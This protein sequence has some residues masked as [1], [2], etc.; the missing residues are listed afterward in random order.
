MLRKMMQRIGGLLAL[1]AITALAAIPLAPQ[2]ALAK[3]RSKAQ[4]TEATEAT[5]V[6]AAPVVPQLPEPPASQHKTMGYDNGFFLETQDGNY[7]LQFQGHFQARF[8]YGFLEQ[9]PDTYTFAVQRGEIDLFGHVLS[10]TLRYFF[11]MNLAT[12]NAATTT[13]VCTDAGCT[14]TANAVT[15]ESTSGVATLNDFFMDWVPIR[16]VGVKFGQYKVPYLIEELTP[17]WKLEFVDRSLASSVF[18][19]FRD[20]GVDV[21]GALANSRIGYDA[22]VMNGAGQNNLDTNQ[23]ILAGVRFEFSIAGKYKRSEADVEYSETPN[24]GVGIAYAFQ[25]LASSAELGT[26]AAG[27]KVSRGTI[28]AS[29]KYRGFSVEA[30]AFVTRTHTGPAITNFGYNAQVGY[31]IVP[32]HFEIA[33]RADGAIV[34]NMPDP[35]EYVLALSYYIDG[36]PIKFQTDFSY[37]L[38][39]RGQGLNDERIR[40]QMTLVF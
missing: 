5:S 7:R 29:L 15:S 38:N 20:I 34:K 1:L 3:A 37:L 36:H 6:I 39:V 4:S 18:D 26:I 13:P 27:T 35:Y 2:A 10:P 24:A 11:E 22:F 28:D 8:T 32:K 21:H 23:S 30:D 16:Q 9:A 40:T 31:F 19:L 17:P 14:T 12:R 25:K 33:M